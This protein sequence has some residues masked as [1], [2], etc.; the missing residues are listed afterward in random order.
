MILTIKGADFSGSGLVTNTSVSISYNGNVTGTPGFIEKNKQLTSTIT[1]KTGYTYNSIT[2][3][4]VGGS[5]ITGYTA[6]DNGNGTVTLTIPANLIT[7]KVV[8]NVNTT[9][10]STGGGEVV[11]PEE[12]GTGGD[13]NETINLLTLGTSNVNTKLGSSD[14]TP[15]SGTGYTTYTDV[16]ITAGSIYSFAYIYRSW[17]KDKNKNDISS[18]NPGSSNVVAPPNAAYVSVTTHSEDTTKIPSITLYYDASNDEIPDGEN[19]ITLGTLNEGKALSSASYTMNTNAEYYVYDQIPVESG[20]IYKLNAGSV[21]AWWLDADKNGLSTVNLASSNCIAVVPT[22][23][24]YFSI[25]IN[26]ATTTIDNAYMI[27]IL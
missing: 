22:N 10:N 17:W 13:S 11:D 16:P 2:S 20:G 26:T 12:P 4:T 27:K 8:V 7:G 5:I 18:F 24:A 15:I 21:R 1:I 25:T 14:S 9:A 19:I 23:A 3:V 6:T